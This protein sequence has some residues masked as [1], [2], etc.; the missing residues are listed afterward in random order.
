L[1]KSV[2]EWWHALGLCARQHR[3][4]EHRS[5][6][7]RVA[8]GRMHDDRHGRRPCRRD[9][10]ALGPHPLPH[11]PPVNVAPGM[12]RA[13]LPWRSHP[14]CVTH[15]RQ[16]CASTGEGDPGRGQ[17]VRSPGPGQRHPQDWQ[18]R[19]RRATIASPARPQG[20]PAGTAC[21]PLAC[22]KE[23]VMRGRHG[24]RPICQCQHHVHLS[25]RL[26]VDARGIIAH[27]W[28]HGWCVQA[29]PQHRD[30]W[31]CLGTSLFL[32]R[33]DLLHRRCT[34]PKST[35]SLHGFRGGRLRCAVCSG[36]GD[37][38]RKEPP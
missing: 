30:R 26:F 16:R 35:M 14:R 18:C 32:S 36:I 27:T 25:P 28:R 6:A 4:P 13:S 19:C 9:G 2:A 37:P 24:T 21:A 3:R 11:S 15:L 34:P 7:C 20:S 31:G 23:I 5:A 1:Q 22:S 10:A 8:T 33:T 12:S 29:C 17:L 38:C